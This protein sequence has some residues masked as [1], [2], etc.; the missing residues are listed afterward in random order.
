MSSTITAASW[1][2]HYYPHLMG[3]KNEAWRAQA[4]YAA[5]QSQ[6]RAERGLSGSLAPG[7]YQQGSHRH[8]QCRSAMYTSHFNKSVLEFWPRPRIS[9]H[10]TRQSSRS[11]LH[12]SVIYVRFWISIRNHWSPSS[13]PRMQRITAGGVFWCSPFWVSPRRQNAALSMCLQRCM[14]FKLFDHLHEILKCNCSHFSS[15]STS[16]RGLIMY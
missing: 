15:S 14:A 11:S 2:K 1:G 4:I 8:S 12:F 10:L 9:E 5:S 3:E 7:K 16:L 13:L 6:E